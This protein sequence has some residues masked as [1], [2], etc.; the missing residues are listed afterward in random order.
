MA[1]PTGESL[2]GVW[3]GGGRAYAVGPGGTVIE[4]DGTSWTAVPTAGIP[5]N[6]N[7]VAVWATETSL[8]V[9]GDTGL[10]ERKTGGTWSAVPGVTWSVDAIWADPTGSDVYAG[11][12][13][14]NTYGLVRVGKSLP[15][16]SPGC[17]PTTGGGLYVGGIWGRSTTMVVVS[18]INLDRICA[19]DGSQ[20]TA[21]PTSSM[22]NSRITG[23]DKTWFALQRSAS[24][25][26]SCGT[27]L[28]MGQQMFEHM[29]STSTTQVIP[30]SVVD[31]AL[32]GSTELVGV[33]ADGLALA[34]DRTNQ[35][36]TRLATPTEVRLTG[37]FAT[38]DDGVFITGESGTVMH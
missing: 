12:Y 17:I 34:L 36:W 19:F 7:L 6:A 22:Y 21:I 1:A 9:G 24:N 29:G 2:C 18:F 32:T 38:P 35:T 16:P 11:G 27:N 28:I 30:G 15:S 3:A 8:F 26:V 14:G 25:T 10:Y 4:L 20:W 5:T 31:I 33:G 37:V 13:Q 23:D